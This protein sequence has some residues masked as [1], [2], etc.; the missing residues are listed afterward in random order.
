VLEIEVGPD[1]VLVDRPISESVADLPAGVVIGAITRDGE[2]VIPRGDTIIREN[3]H[4]VCFL[5][6]SI[7]D[8]ATEL[9]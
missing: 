2:F 8:E 3:D 6:A 7:I 9:L 1:S 4:V 5:D